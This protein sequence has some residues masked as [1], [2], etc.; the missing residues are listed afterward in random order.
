MSSCACVA[1]CYVSERA[2]SEYMRERSISVKEGCGDDV[3]LADSSHVGTSGMSSRASTTSKAASV[4]VTRASTLKNVINKHCE[5]VM[6]ILIGSKDSIDK[7]KS[8]ES[9][10]RACHE[11]FSELFTAY[12]ALLSEKSVADGVKI[13][14]IKRAVIEVLGDEERLYGLRAVVD[15][16]GDA[17]PRSV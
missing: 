3:Y 12:I 15:G 13:D 5:S 10:F 17:F 14:E 2:E 6:N 7:K 9:A 16:S 11:A 1:S 8:V 4:T